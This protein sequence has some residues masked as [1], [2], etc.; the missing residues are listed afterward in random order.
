MVLCIPC[1]MPAEHSSPMKRTMGLLNLK[2]L[3]VCG[4]Y[5]RPYLY[6]HKCEVFT[7]HEAIKS[8]LNTP[9]SSGKLARW[10]LAL[11]EVELEVQY[12]AGR[13]NANAEMQKIR[14][15]N[16]TTC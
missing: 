3:G 14:F 7:D 16:Q 9:H 11:Q 6:G 8:L 2:P 13:K 15:W 4:N 10:G 12:C 1:P 5:F